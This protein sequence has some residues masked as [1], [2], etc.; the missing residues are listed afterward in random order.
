[1]KDA[2]PTTPAGIDRC[3]VCSRCS[4]S[5]M[6]RW[7]PAAMQTQATVVA[8][9]TVCKLRHFPSARTFRIDGNTSPRRNE[10]SLFCGE[11]YILFEI[12][13]VDFAT[14]KKV[15][16]NSLIVYVCCLCLET[17]HLIQYDIFRRVYDITK[18]DFYICHVTVYI[19]QF[20]LLTVRTEI[21][22]SNSTDF[23][24]V[25]C[26]SIFRKF[27]LENSGFVKMGKE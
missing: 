4:P 18:S 17:L 23:H 13:L 7:Q 11:E 10:G 26:L 2:I 21:I 3:R 9:Q 5:G 14:T 22:R 16:K 15:F 12:S 24:E 25:C 19:R 20:V 8:V 6:T 1:M 27:Y